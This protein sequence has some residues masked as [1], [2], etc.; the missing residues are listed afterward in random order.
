MRILLPLLLSLTSFAETD[1][2]TV[3]PIKPIT[4]AVGKTTT[5]TVGATI[6]KGYHVQGN[7]ASMPNLIPTSLTPENSAGFTTGTPTY[8]K[9]KLWKLVGTDTKVAT[10]DGKIEIKLPITGKVEGK[11]ELKAILRYQACN[12]R[13]CFPPVKTP[14]TIPVT[15][16]K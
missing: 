4:V 1:R 10:F 7:P 12:E 15:V 13:N 5:A 16:T 9:S 6:E 14:V 3:Q 2:L 8:P 11:H